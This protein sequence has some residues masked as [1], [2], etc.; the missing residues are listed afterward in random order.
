MRNI[1]SVL[2]RLAK[3]IS[4]SLVLLFAVT[5]LHAQDVKEGQALFK[6][7]CTSCHGITKK[8]VGPALAGMTE[9]HPD[10]ELLGMLL[11]LNFSK[12][13]TS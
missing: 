3:S 11:L 4:V 5:T 1:S 12:R 10:E 6:A 8:L 13:T 7:K 9:R 2:E